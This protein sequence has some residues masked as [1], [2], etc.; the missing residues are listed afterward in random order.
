[1]SHSRK[2]RRDKTES[3]EEENSMILYY[4]GTGNSEYAAK[5]IGEGIGDEVLN[6]FEKLRDG[7]F[8]EMHSEK[9]WVVVTPV[10]AWR[11][12]RI[13]REWLRKTKLTGNSDIY[14]V[15]TCGAGIGNAGKY[16]KELCAE[17]GLQDRGCLEVLMPENYIA[18]FSP[19][20]EAEARKIIGRAEPVLEQAA[21]AVRSGKPFPEKPVT[22]TD[23][24]LSGA[25]N[26]LFYPLFIHAKKFHVT[27]ACV[28]CGNC[29]KVC[30]FQ[31]VRLKDG[32]PV[33][34]DRCTH[35]MACICRCPKNAIEYGKHSRGLPRYT[36]PAFSEEAEGEPQKITQGEPQAQ[37]SEKGSIE[38]HE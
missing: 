33:W 16:V 13:V 10:Y 8:S 21:E 34:G 1:M 22:L 37:S 17:K 30:P 14:F 3:P 12:P 32:K 31:N 25:V 11:I 24:I 6:L 5:R 7:D 20:A 27:D 15:L 4:S 23:R 18:L 2:T 9:P 28:S 35:C 29:V 19:P 38:E 36:F 26:D